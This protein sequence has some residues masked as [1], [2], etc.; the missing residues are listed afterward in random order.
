MNRLVTD[1]EILRHL[2]EDRAILDVRAPVEF[3]AGSVP[4]SVN[5][6][7]LDNEQRAAVGTLYKAEGAS[8]A[9][10]LGFELI[11]GA[12]HSQRVDVWSDF[13]E[14]HTEAA[15]MCFRG[16]QRSQLVQREL[17]RNGID[18]PLVEGG[19]KRIRNL[20]SQR[21]DRSCE[22]LNWVV[23][24]GFT[25]S[26]KTQL[27]RD[28]QIPKLDLEKSAR[29]RGSVFGNWPGG[30][31]TPVSFEN[32]LGLSASKLLEFADIASNRRH[33]LEDESRSIGRLVLPK[34]LFE[35]LSGAKVWVLERP[36]AERARRLV[37]EYLS[38]NYNF[39]DGLRV[40]NLDF[41]VRV[42]QSRCDIGRAI[43]K[44]ERR[45]GG[46]ETKKLL[47]MTDEAT[48]EFERNG[49]FSAHWPWVER[50]LEIYYDPLYEK[51]LQKIASRVI[52]R[53]PEE[54]F[55]SLAEAEKGRF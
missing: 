53:G 32:E 22:K 46:A 3:A 49:R 28:S 18:V 44:I 12:T 24:S 5:L 45:L 43:S 52:G 47:A 15:I 30:Q 16:G 20:L 2:H 26:G 8:R 48:R 33:W 23:L 35:T 40:S 51:H 27:L 39:S 9:L 10:D 41:E 19:F 1:D 17:N 4:N 11:S 14:T 38:E 7:L 13:L 25:G 29:H 21:L 55:R 54:E 36:R 50:L 31:P 6:P 34:A 42:E 37:H